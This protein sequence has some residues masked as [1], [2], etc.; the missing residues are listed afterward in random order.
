MLRLTKIDN[1]NLK[2]VI[3]LSELFESSVRSREDFLDTI[4]EMLEV[5]T[6][7]LNEKTYSLELKETR[8]IIL[9]VELY[10]LQ[11][12]I[13]ELGRDIIRYSVPKEDTIKNIIKILNMLKKSS[14]VGGK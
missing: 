7:F 4:T 8:H 2:L 14:F 9:K 13:G 10:N 11:F 12:M 1:K 3:L 5:S 6:S